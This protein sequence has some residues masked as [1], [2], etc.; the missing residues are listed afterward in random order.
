M[1]NVPEYRKKGLTAVVY[2]A[3]PKMF[4]ILYEL[5]FLLVD[6]YSISL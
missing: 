3:P 6:F 2:G 4:A 1:Q 5:A